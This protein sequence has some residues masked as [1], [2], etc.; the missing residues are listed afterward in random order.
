MPDEPESDAQRVPESDAQRVSAFLWT[1]YDDLDALVSL[2]EVLFLVP[3]RLDQA[4]V[5]FVRALGSAWPGV[6]E[7]SAEI[8][9]TVLDPNQLPALKK[10]GLTGSQLDLKLLAWKRARA[11]ADAVFKDSDDAEARG[12]GD[13]VGSVPGLGAH[14][15][16]FTRKRPRRL[17]TA[18]RWVARMLSHGDTL[19]GSLVRAFTQLDAVKEI[20]ETIEKTAGD[21]S[22]E[23]PAD[24]P[25]Q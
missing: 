8:L 10:Y 2:R 1:L 5:D 12:S 18:L 19:L 14:E 3:T 11:H 15:P 7:G 9:S 25:A 22:G 21:I 16:P 4:G 17:K 24:T 13:P 23:L 20:K 6:K